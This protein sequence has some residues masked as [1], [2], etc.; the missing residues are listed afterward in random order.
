MVYV[1]INHK[2]GPIIIK[3]L[4]GKAAKNIFDLWDSIRVEECFFGTG[5]INESAFY[6]LTLSKQVMDYEEVDRAE[7][8][9][10]QA[11]VSLCHVWKFASGHLMVLNQKYYDIRPKYE[12]NAQKV[13]ECIMKERNLKSVS[14]YITTSTELVGSYDEMP[15]EKAVELCKKAKNDAYLRALFKYYYEGC[16]NEEFW[17]I[18]IYYVK[19]ILLQKFKKNKIKGVLNINDDDWGNFERELN[20]YRNRHAPKIDMKKQKVIKNEKI[21]TRKIAYQWIESYIKTL[22]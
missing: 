22:K 5:N 3:S 19:D 8:A 11:L 18:P 14:K 2:E 9:L 15:L 10:I 16:V 20:D 17:Y 7:G 12:S 21:D 6:Q 1:N 13:K 4:L